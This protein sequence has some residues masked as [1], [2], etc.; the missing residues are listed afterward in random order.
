MREKRDLEAPDRTRQFP[1]AAVSHEWSG[2]H[3]RARRRPTTVYLIIDLESSQPKSARVVL[4]NRERLIASWDSVLL[5][6][7]E[8]ESHMEKLCDG[9]ITVDEAIKSMGSTTDF[10][11][12]HTD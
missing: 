7:P 5:S 1:G 9:T 8:I 10:G 11:G 4:R 12:D 3:Q 6:H 2:G